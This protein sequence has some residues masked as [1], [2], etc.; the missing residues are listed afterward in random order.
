MDECVLC[1]AKPDSSGVIYHTSGC[2]IG[3]T[4]DVF[5]SKQGLTFATDAM[6]MGLLRNLVLAEYRYSWEVLNTDLSVGAAVLAVTDR[7]H[8][9]IWSPDTVSALTTWL[10]SAT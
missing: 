8:G 2:S 1:G 7:Y 4:A 3:T 6:T 9:V 5:Y 10:E